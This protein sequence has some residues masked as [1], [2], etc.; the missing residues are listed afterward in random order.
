MV[1]FLYGV[2]RTQSF[3]AC[4]LEK[5][6]VIWPPVI[7]VENQCFETETLGIYI[8]SS[9]CLL[10]ILLSLNLKLV[11]CLVAY[12]AQFYLIQFYTLKYKKDMNKLDTLPLTCLWKFDLYGQGTR[13]N[14]FQMYW[15]ENLWLKRIMM[16]FWTY[17]AVQRHW[18][19]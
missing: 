15:F 7:F 11:N 2:K 9:K 14:Q 1:T 16:S 6:V 13:E 3:E 19:V 4:L 10:F 8:T 18:H 12:E 5:K 17:F